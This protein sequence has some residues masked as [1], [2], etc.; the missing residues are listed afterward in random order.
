MALLTAGLAALSAGQSIYNIIT[1]ARQVRKARKLTGEYERLLQNRPE[2]ATPEE[3]MRSAEIARQEYA[4]GR[5]PGEGL[6]YDRAALSQ[7]NAASQAAQGGNAFAGAV[8]TQAQ[9][10]AANQQ[11]QAQSAQYRL[12]AQAAYQQQ[13]AQV[14]QYRDQEWQM[15]EFAKFSDRA[16]YLQGQIRDNQQA[17]AYNVSSGLGSLGRTAASMFLMTQM[18]KTGADGGKLNDIFNRYGGAKDAS[19]TPYVN[20][21]FNRPTINS[22]MPGTINPNTPFPLGPDMMM[23]IAQML[24]G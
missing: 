14:G 16:Q 4:S 17:G 19:Q 22:P 6:A 7:A 18:G 20:P 21:F 24:P 15:N 10:N 2:Y 1:G 5:M 11:T 12:Q 8:A 13:L 23:R 3:V 9:T